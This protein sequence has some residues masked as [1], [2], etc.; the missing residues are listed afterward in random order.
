MEKP[1]V[2]FVYIIQPAFKIHCWED[3]GKE[4]CLKV[5]IAYNLGASTTDAHNW[6]TKYLSNYADMPLVRE[7]EISENIDLRPVLLIE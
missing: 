3:S 5:L 2:I 7:I 6:F 1:P 4:C